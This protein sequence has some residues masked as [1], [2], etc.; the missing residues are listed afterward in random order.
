MNKQFANYRIREK[1]SSIL[2]PTKLV[3]AFNA[4]YPD[5]SIGQHITSLLEKDS[6]R[7]HDTGHILALLIEDVL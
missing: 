7:L 5:Q 4:K 2:I 1:R 6:Y 3:D